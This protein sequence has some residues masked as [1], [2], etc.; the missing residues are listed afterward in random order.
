M[1]FGFLIQPFFHW[2]LKHNNYFH[3]YWVL[4]HYY[5][6]RYCRFL[7]FCSR[8][9]SS[10]CVDIAVVMDR[11]W[12]GDWFILMQVALRNDLVEAQKVFTSLIIW[13]W[14]S[15]NIN[16]IFASCVRTWTQ[17]SSTSSSLT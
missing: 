13:G 11:L 1:Y 14:G 6:L 7:V 5:F 3:R 15:R 9:K 12:F 8:A 10:S 2:I 17:L 4:N 16:V